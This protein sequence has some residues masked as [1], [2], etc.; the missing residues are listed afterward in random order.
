M[1]QKQI[2]I[3]INVEDKQ[4]DIAS[5]RTLTL[6]QQIKIL[7]QELA[8]GSLGQKEFELVAAKVGDLEDQMARARRRSADF[9]TTLQLIPGPIGEIASKVN[10][11]IALL[12]QFSGFSFKD[13]QFQFKET[14]NDI[15]EIFSNLGSFGEK[16]REV[17]DTQEELNDVTAQGT[18]VNASAGQAILQNVTQNQ[19]AINT[20]NKKIKI[21]TDYQAQLIQEIDLLKEQEKEVGKNSEAGKEIAAQKKVYNEELKASI[22]YQKR[23]TSEVETLTKAQ[24]SNTASAKKDAQAQGEVAVA[25]EVATNTTKTQTT[26]TNA[27]TVAQ[28]TASAAGRILKGVL[29]SL[30][31]GLIIALV[32]TAATKFYEWIKS[33]NSTEAAS[34]KFDETLQILNRSI[35]SNLSLVDEEIEI[36]KIRAQTAGATEKQINDITISGINKRIKVLEEG[37]K[38][39][40]QQ[41]EELLRQGFSKEEIKEKSKSIEDEYTKLGSKIIDLQQTRRIQE[42]KG[43]QALANDRKKINEKSIADA[44]TSRKEKLA[45]DKAELDAKIQLLINEKNTDKKLLEKYLEERLQ[46]ELQGEKRSNAEKQLLRQENSKRVQDAVKEDVDR[47]YQIRL[48]S[49]EAIIETEQNQSD[50]D[51]ERLKKLLLHKRDLELQNTELLNE[52]RLMIISKYDRQIRDIE[53][54]QREDKL[55]SDIA[56][57]RGDFDKQ[58][59]L[60]RQFSQEILDSEKY[61]EQEK[62][63]IIQDSNDKIKQLQEERFQS[64]LDALELEFGATYSYDSEYYDKLR[65]LYE[66]EEQRYKALR[67]SKQ[68]TDAEYTAFLKQNSQTKRQLDQEELDAKMANF[69][70]VSQLFAASSALVGEQTKA[71]KAFAIAGAT[72]DTYVAANQVIRD[73]T[74]PTFLKVISAAGIIIKGLANVKKIAEVK[75]PTPGGD[76]GGGDTGTKPMGTINVN[77]QRRAQGGIVY[78]PGSETSD[79]IPAFLSNGEYVVN[80]RS[81]RMFQPLLNMINGYGNNTPSFAMGGLVSQQPSPQMET[82]G[83]IVEA[84]ERGISNQPIRTYVTSSDVTN[85]QQFDRIIKSRSLI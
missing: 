24:T 45:R 73:P 42:V 25:S 16:T 15:K 30:G 17:I 32:T 4:V 47:E 22:A 19:Q 10:G 67:D 79:S 80:A 34:K 81:T 51:V 69:Q 46:L 12:K 82:S 7:K 31:I 57:T 26:A 64:R 3:L 9:A 41:E 52:E 40:A 84:I 59:E 13:L 33:I 53:T 55:V 38:K 36:Q 14:A 75:L 72:I 48:K 54:K 28:N 66:Q 62:I 78:G 18:S 74:I 35:E 21:E 65:Q 60:Y 58:I 70:A 71:G 83:R 61:T 76:T 37:R 49:I 8:K 20:L 63:K 5:K 2:E 6:T 85:Q 44:E 23:F 11:A 1:A 29:F 43:E 77:A 50:I 56:S 27:L 39:L 68:I